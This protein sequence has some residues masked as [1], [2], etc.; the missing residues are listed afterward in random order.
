MLAR[1]LLDRHYGSFEALLLAI[2]DVLAAQVKGLPCACLQVDEANVPGN[3]ADG[4]LAAA[5][6]N[7]VLDAFEGRRAVHLCFGNY[8]GQTIQGGEWRALTAFLN[9]LHVDHLVLE[10]AHRPSDDLAAISAVDPRIRLGIGVV[11]VKVNHIETP[12]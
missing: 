12:R 1:T 10:M 9:A 3:P 8:G 4:P 2:A 11:D 7:R 6:I 5:A